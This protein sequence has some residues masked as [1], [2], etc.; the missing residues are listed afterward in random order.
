MNRKNYCYPYFW[1]QR[2][3]KRRFL[4]KK[5]T[6]EMEDKFKEEKIKWIEH[7]KEM[8]EKELEGVNERLKELKP[9]KE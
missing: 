5:E 1:H 6:K 3:W 8:L 4:T 2:L 9:K 7:Y